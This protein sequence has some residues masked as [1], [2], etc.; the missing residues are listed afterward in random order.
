MEHSGDSVP[1]TEEAAAAE[2]QKMICARLRI[3]IKTFN[4]KLV[5][6]LTGTQSQNLTKI[7]KY[8]Q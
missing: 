7:R 1:S 3:V 6:S 2:I 8:N 4:S 5:K